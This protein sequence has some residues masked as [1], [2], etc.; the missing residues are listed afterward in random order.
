VETFR[1]LQY[2][3]RN[4]ADPAYVLDLALR[5]QDLARLRAISQYLIT[6]KQ[7]IGPKSSRQRQAEKWH[8][9]IK[10]P[11]DIRH[12]VSEWDCDNEEDVDGHAQVLNRWLV[13]ERVNQ[14]EL[15][16]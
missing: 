16:R 14:T 2:Y 3:S 13:T 4:V 9:S 1:Q 8:A 10:P 12:L 6:N 15:E 11:A 7:L 5:I